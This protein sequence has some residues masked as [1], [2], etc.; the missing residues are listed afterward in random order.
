MPSKITWVEI[1]MGCGLVAGGILLAPSIFGMVQQQR[2]AKW[3]LGLTA[4]L[5]FIPLCVGLNRGN[6]LSDIARDII[7]L[8]FLLVVPILLIY[9]ASTANR[10]VLCMWTTISLLFVGIVSA[11][12]FYAGALNSAGSADQIISGGINYIRESQTYPAAQALQSLHESKETQELHESQVDRYRQLFLKPYDP[13]MFFSAT[14]LSSWGVI[15]IAGSWRGWLPGLFLAGFG[16]SIAY[17]FMLLGLRAYT[18]FFVMALAITCLTQLRKKGF[19]VRVLPIIFVAMVVF[20]PQIGAALHL[21]WFKQQTIGFNGKG[22]E[23]ISVADAVLNSTETALFGIG[24]GG[25]LSNPIYMNEVT[26][27][28]HSVVSYYL[29]KS[30]VLGLIALISIVYTLFLVK[31]NA[32]GDAIFTASRK[33]VLISCLPPLLIG[34]LFEPTYKMLSYGVILALFVLATPLFEKKV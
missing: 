12:I 28:T 14:F 33:V 5:L 30:G 7:P 2:T 1:L 6:A 27:F 21:L 3:S 8:V 15:L 23:W 4:L 9:S 24:W 22:A 34:L 16:A 10:M 20:W 18:A 32:G 11:I 31:R 26:R 19:Y 29:L 13:A 17:I 25:V